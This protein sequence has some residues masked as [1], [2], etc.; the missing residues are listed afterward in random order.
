MSGYISRFLARFRTSGLINA[1]AA[2][3]VAVSAL[4]APAFAQTQLLNVSYDP[5]RE[6]YQQINRAFMPIGRRKR[7]R[8]S[9]STSRMAALAAKRAQ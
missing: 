4:S 7:A 9:P 6:L 2:A 3:I 5:T 8:S 1:F